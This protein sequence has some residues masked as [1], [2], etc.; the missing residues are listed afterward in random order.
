MVSLVSGVLT[1]CSSKPLIV[2]RA[3]YLSKPPVLLNASR[4]QILEQEKI[5]GVDTILNI[6]VIDLVR[7]W[8]ESAFQCSG[9]GSP[10]NVEIVEASLAP[11]NVVED[12]GSEDTYVAVLGV[13]V[14]FGANPLEQSASSMVNSKV[15]RVIPARCS[16]KERRKLA[17]NLV[18]EA[19]E[20]LHKQVVRYI[21]AHP[22]SKR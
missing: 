14:F 7:Q 11:A 15:S 9:V 1:G 4:I 12:G 18:E 8:A 13:R 3:G 20:M 22:K 2:P 6:S 19:I 16:L 10:L 17:I 5:D 21:E